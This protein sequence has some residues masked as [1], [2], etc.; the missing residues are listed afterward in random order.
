MKDLSKAMRCLGFQISHALSKLT[1]LL[2]QS[3]YV[4]PILNRFQMA[5]DRPV[6]TLMEE[7]RVLKSE[8]AENHV[9]SLEQL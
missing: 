5:E 3:K 1:L 7:R 4:R 6:D 2:N 8:R 9:F